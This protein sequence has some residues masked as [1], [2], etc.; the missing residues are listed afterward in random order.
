MPFTTQA[1]TFRA[2]LLAGAAA[3]ALAGAALAQTAPAS[4]PNP[5]S[6]PP[7]SATS[8]GPTSGAS[9]T[10]QVH[11]SLE[12]QQGGATMRD[13][14]AAQRQ[15]QS[16]K[17][18]DQDDD[19][20]DDKGGDNGNDSRAT[21]MELQHSIMM[22]AGLATIHSR[23]RLS[24]D[25]ER[26]WQPVEQAVRN[27]AGVMREARAGMADLDEDNPVDMLRKMGEAASDHGEAMEK[28]ADAAEPLWN[29]LDDGQKRRLRSVLSMMHE[30]MHS[31]MGMMS[32]MSRGMRDRD[33]DDRSGMDDRRG[34]RDRMMRD[35]MDRS[36]RGFW[37]DDDGRRGHDFH[38]WRRNGDDRGR[39]G[40]W[41]DDN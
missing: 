27:L 1:K 3:F 20:D 37:R 40:G 11:P 21:A 7:A 9:G 28:L 22:E 23:L 24:G 25:Q 36:D 14:D 16:A 41:D 38:H 35:R 31:G 8:P 19:D 5:G 15:A 29:A 13:T 10:T 26:L 34:M 18:D 17:P 2:S 33:N 39:R 30:R 6:S 32:G 12:A 4:P